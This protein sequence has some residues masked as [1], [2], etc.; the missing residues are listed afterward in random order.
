M[1]PKTSNEEIGAFIGHV[2]IAL[3]GF[4]LG[5]HCIVGWSFESIAVD[6]AAGDSNLGQVGEIILGLQVELART[7]RQCI[8]VVP[9]GSL[10]VTGGEAIAEFTDLVCMNGG[11]GNGSELA[12]SELERGALH[13]FR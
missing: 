12:A 6:K 5:G 10:V 8:P 1:I 11:T 3:S 4:C 7:E 2:S 9:L 13:F